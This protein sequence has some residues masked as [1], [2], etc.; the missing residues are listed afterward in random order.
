[1]NENKSL[2]LITTEQFYKL[3]NSKKFEYINSLFQLKENYLVGKT[4]HQYVGQSFLIIEDLLNPY[5]GKQLPNQ[6]FSDLN[7][8]KLNA[9]SFNTKLKD[10]DLTAGS[11]ILFRFS[12]SMNLE[13]IKQGEVLVVRKECIIPVETAGDILRE[14]ELTEEDI[15]NVK[16]GS[17]FAE[18][19]YI[20]DF[21]RET[22]SNFLLDKKTKLD[23]YSEQ[24]KNEEK[25]LKNKVNELDV[26]EKEIK[27]Q[28]KRAYV[29]IEKEKQKAEEEINKEKNH[30][31][32]KEQRI[33]KE[34]KQIDTEI[35]KLGF[36]LK[37][38]FPDKISTSETKRIES[39]DPPELETDFIKAIQLQIA[40]RGLNYNL[41]TIRKFYTALKTNQFIILS[42]PSGT[43]KTSLISA[44]AE[45]TASYSKV[46][47]VQPSWTDKQDL[48]GFYNPLDKQYVPSL[49]LDAII[50]AKKHKNRLYLICLDELNLAQ[51]EYY[52]ADILSLR[53]QQNIPI[54]LYS[55]YEYEQ[56]IAE[57]NW[58]V[59]KSLQLEDNRDK[60]PLE[61]LIQDSMNI[62]T[63]DQ[64]RYAQR[65]SNIKRYH[66]EIHIPEN[67][68][69]IGTMN[70]DGTVRPLSPK[71]VDRSFII[72]LNRQQEEVE[73]PEEKL[74][75]N[76]PFSQFNE[77]IELREETNLKQTLINQLETYLTSLDA[78]FN[79][80]VENHIDDYIAISQSLHVDEAKIFDEIISMKLLPRINKMIDYDTDGLDEFF[81]KV[82]K[83]TANHQESTTK[84]ELMIEKAEQTKIFSYWS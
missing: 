51:I 41:D 76:L 30:L 77:S 9:I 54:E 53:E 40:K 69:F 20:S 22:V 48:L 10:Y 62:K 79:N 1:M 60:T 73:K 28:E 26:R 36:S 46:I 39:I 56:N 35:K 82:K 72:T 38:F 3:S 70:I 65:Y 71:V 61:Q 7:T 80:R 75:F 12:F 74:V 52:F 81:N 78:H 11:L 27:E 55:K 68:R 32:M 21:Y 19:G 31:L 5:T 13:N 44:F 59:Q 43:G 67:V 34:I 17:E 47:P 15:L 4:T 24:L 84:I 58:F 8:W 64:F 66:W 16:S 63:I 18:I 50:E 45:V 49:F 2:N 29:Q 42:G 14:L 25:E 83:L 57:I 23:N 37:N 33:Y 6:L